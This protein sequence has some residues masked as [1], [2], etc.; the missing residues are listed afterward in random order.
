LKKLAS[1]SDMSTF[2]D[3]V[4]TIA[5]NDLLHLPKKIFIKKLNDFLFYLFESAYQAD[6][7]VKSDDPSM[8]NNNKGF[9]FLVIP[10]KTRPHDWIDVGYTLMYDGAVRVIT[11]TQTYSKP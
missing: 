10:N 6:W 9:K 8:G 1:V 5:C 11:A 4:I 2:M 7:L 3:S